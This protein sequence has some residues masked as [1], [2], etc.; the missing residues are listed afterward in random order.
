MRD[1]GIADDARRAPAASA[2]VVGTE[3]VADGRRRMLTALAGV[4]MLTLSN[5]LADHPCCALL[6]AAAVVVTQTR[7]VSVIDTMGAFNVDVP[8]FHCS[9][10]GVTSTVL[11]SAVGCFEVNTDK[12]VAASRLWITST[13]LDLLSGLLAKGTTFESAFV[14]ICGAVFLT[15]RRRFRSLVDGN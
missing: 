9:T 3:R 1:L 13:M 11:A 10:C 6:E 15:G 5:V 8:T 12:T 7:V 2:M 14:A 4:M